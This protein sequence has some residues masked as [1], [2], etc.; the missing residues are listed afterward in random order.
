MLAGD[1]VKRLPRLH[2]N[3]LRGSGDGCA[4]QQKQKGKEVT[5]HSPCYFSMPASE[6]DEGQRP[7]VLPGKVATKPAM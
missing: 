6:V 2:L 4:G 7:G 3:G 5:L 1:A